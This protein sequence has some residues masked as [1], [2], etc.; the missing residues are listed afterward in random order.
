MQ[1]TLFNRD[2]SVDVTEEGEN[3]R[4]VGTLEDT[5]MGNALHGI[6]V[7]MVVVSWSA[8]IL[9][10]SGTMPSHPMEQCLDG[11]ESLQSLVGQRIVPGF[12]DMVKSTVGSQVG[13]THLASLVM[14]M[15]NVSVLG[16]Y[17]YMR[18]HVT[19][20]SARAAVMLE[21]ADSLNLLNSCVCWHE[22]GPLLKRWKA[23]HEGKE[24]K[25]LG[26]MSH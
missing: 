16:R 3:L 17:S 11:L 1:V 5:R 25:P 4:L 7:E 26:F 15:G 22:D 23:E 21:T 13:C 18:E 19:E 14:N 10:V 9:E 24:G 20:E 8:E 2:I 12:S 6:R